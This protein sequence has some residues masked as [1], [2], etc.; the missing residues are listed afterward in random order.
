LQQ[1]TGVA[2]RDGPHASGG[3]TAVQAVRV[4]YDELETVRAAATGADALFLITPGNPHQ[5]R[6][7]C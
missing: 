7:D 2:V 3:A 4:D 6:C 5:E 1:G